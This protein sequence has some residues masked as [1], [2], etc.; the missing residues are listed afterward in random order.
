[1]LQRK[2]VSR[3]PQGAVNMALRAGEE[4]TLVLFAIDCLEKYRSAFGTP[5]NFATFE[6]EGTHY[7][8]IDRI[9]DMVTRILA[10]YGEVSE[11]FQPF[12][13]VC[14]WPDAFDSYDDVE[15]S[16]LTVYRTPPRDQLLR[17][18]EEI[19]N[20]VKLRS[21]NEFG[22][23]KLTNLDN[24]LREHI[25][26]IEETTGVFL[27]P[28]HGRNFIMFDVAEV[29]SFEDAW[30]EV[31][32]FWNAKLVRE[33]GM[34]LR[35]TAEMFVPMI[36]LSFGAAYSESLRHELSAKGSDKTSDD[37]FQQLNTRAIDALNISHKNGGDRITIW[38]PGLRDR[39]QGRP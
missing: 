12:Q 19:K 31:L 30:E 6:F 39:F 25:E 33:Y 18:L 5:L 37:L 34:S 27:S 7:S 38:D 29:L 22:A 36:T 28:F 35:G 26:K 9:R 11:D 16:V 17:V 15:K 14:P 32:R 24:A 21:T 13:G 3:R 23:G 8:L 4:V 10:D 1:M 20:S 2:S